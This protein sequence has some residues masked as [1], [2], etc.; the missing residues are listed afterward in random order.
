VSC[1]P[2][3]PLASG[4]TQRVIAQRD[5]PDGCEERTVSHREGRCVDCGVLVVYLL[6]DVRVLQDSGFDLFVTGPRHTGSDVVLVE[7]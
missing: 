4:I 7:A 6:A 3:R 1:K 5:T 2:H